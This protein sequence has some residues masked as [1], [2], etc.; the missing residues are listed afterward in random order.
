VKTVLDGATKAERFVARPM[1]RSRPRLSP[2]GRAIA[3][4]DFSGLVSVLDAVSG[5]EFIK[6]DG[7]KGDIRCL[8]FSPDG[9]LLAAGDEGGT[10]C[11]W[12]SGTGRLRSRFTCYNRARQ[13]GP[14]AAALVVLGLATLRLRRARRGVVVARGTR[15]W[16]GI[17]RKL[18]VRIPTSIQPGST[19]SAVSEGQLLGQEDTSAN[20]EPM[21][22]HWLDG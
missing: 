6:A 15:F 20:P 10:V 11:V 3:F 21:W 18:F 12:E 1:S 14:T 7:L 16:N 2:D 4:G 13:W 9:T 17:R 5:R 22:D 19:A 8:A